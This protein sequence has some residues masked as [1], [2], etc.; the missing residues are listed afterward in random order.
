MFFCINSEK[1]SLAKSSFFK[2]AVPPRINWDSERVRFSRVKLNSLY[3][4]AGRYQRGFMSSRH[5]DLDEKFDDV[6]IRPLLRKRNWT[7]RKVA[8]PHRA[9]QGFLLERQTMNRTNGG[10]FPCDDATEREKWSI[11]RNLFRQI[12]PSIA[13]TCFICPIPRDTDVTAVDR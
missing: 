12:R 10:R 6:L 8:S 13:L 5:D 2:K 7:C 3:F 1:N 11:P 9:A 4:S